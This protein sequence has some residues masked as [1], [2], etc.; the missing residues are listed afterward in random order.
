MEQ[1]EPRKWPGEWFEKVSLCPM[2]GGGER[3]PFVNGV[4]DWFFSCVP[5][6]FSLGHCKDCTTLV[7]DERPDADH[8]AL[9]YENY[10]TH[11]PGN[12][13]N[14]PSG[15]AD[16]LKSI[17]SGAYV[18]HRYGGSR[19]LSDKA[20][21]AFFRRF[22]ARQLEIDVKHRFMPRGKSDILDF[23]CGNGDFLRLAKSFGHRVTGVDFDEGAREAARSQG[24]AY[25]LPD[26]I[27]DGA[28]V[29]AFDHVTIAHV[30]EHV[31][32]PVELLARVRRWL[33]PGGTLFVEVPNADAAG[34][35]KFG[36]FWRGLE[37]PRHFSIPTARS[38]QAGLERAGF[39]DTS[40]V[41][42]S[43]VADWLWPISAEAM[44]RHGAREAEVALPIASPGPEFLT[45]TAR[46]N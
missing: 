22:P 8:I 15:I 39:V 33:R 3:V 42:R 21:A 41:A 11:A 24:I 32:D 16:K 37:A 26:E 14:A 2:C 5:G 4:E 17:V 27:D 31:P 6:S 23:G 44:T 30:I 20:I 1:I 45:V 29:S 46:A 7:L 18:S 40:F 35:A 28:F 12:G 25:L 43:S 19:A 38:L 13:K 10:Y 36:R 9:A 34:L